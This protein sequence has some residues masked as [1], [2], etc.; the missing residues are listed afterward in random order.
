VAE[1]VVGL[2]LVILLF[3]RRKDILLDLANGLKG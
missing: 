1:V 3:R 2:A